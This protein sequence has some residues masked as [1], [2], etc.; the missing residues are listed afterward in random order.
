MKE[1]PLIAIIVG[2]VALLYLA[3]KSGWIGANPT[4]AIPVGKGVYAPQPA[5][6]Y[7]GYLAASTAPGV[8]NA[9][10]GII[11][12]IGGAVSGWLH[13]PSVNTPAPAVRAAAP[14]GANQAVST[15][16]GP[17]NPLGISNSNDPALWTDPLLYDNTNVTSF[18][19]DQIAADNAFDPSYSLMTDPSLLPA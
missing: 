2:G 7:S 11:S 18:A 5:Q 8:S 13:S 10:N 3:V 9:L 1:A 14:T 4:A 12:G 19:Y 6:N 17:S 15:G 16:V